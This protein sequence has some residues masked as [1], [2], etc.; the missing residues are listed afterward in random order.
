MEIRLRPKDFKHLKE[1]SA[2]NNNY[3]EY[4]GKEA[5]TKFSILEKCH[6]NYDFYEYTLIENEDEVFL[7]CSR[8]SFEDAEVIVDFR[9]FY[10]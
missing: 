6:E 3:Y 5:N 7:G 4:I 2:Y 9:L 8:D 1:K 10:T